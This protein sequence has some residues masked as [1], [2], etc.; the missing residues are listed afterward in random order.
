MA[1]SVAAKSAFLCM[2]MKNHPDTLVAYVKHYGKVAGNVV[3]AEMTAIDSKGMTIKY[4]LKSG[5]DGQV[6]VSFQ[7]PL[8]GYDEVKPRLLS[9]KVDAQESLGMIKAPHLTTFSLSAPMV[10]AFFLVLLSC[11]YVTVYPPRGTSFQIPF[12]TFEIPSS[13]LD[14]FFA[15]IRSLVDLTGYRP[16]VG[17]VAGTFSV[18]HAAESLYTWS[19]C[20]RYVRGWSVKAVYVVATLIFGMP[21]WRDIHRRVQQKRIESVMKA[22]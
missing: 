14:V 13:V 7:P 15:P 8:A 9:M 2:Y 5:A 22:E 10:H 17:M 1:D 4:K 3:S 21:V 20:Q 6:V 19:L 12:T 11:S 18:L 16:S